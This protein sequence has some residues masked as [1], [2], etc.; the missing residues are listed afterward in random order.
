MG[1]EVEVLLCGVWVCIIAGC[2]MIPI[3]CGH[4]GVGGGEVP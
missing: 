4:S 2:E 3:C 1:G